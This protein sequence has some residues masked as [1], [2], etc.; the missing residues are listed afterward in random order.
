MLVVVVEGLTDSLLSRV[1]TPALD[2][3]IATGVMF[4]LEPEFPAETLPTI[5]S[6][7]TGKHTEIHGVIDTEVEEGGGTL[8]YRE[9]DFWN[10]NPNIS[11]LWSLNEEKHHK[12]G[13]VWWPGTECH[14]VDNQTH[15]ALLIWKNSDILDNNSS[16]NSNQTKHVEKRSIVMN[17]ELEE[18]STTIDDYELEEEI[19]IQDNDGDRKD[20]MT[21]VGDDM[22]LNTLDFNQS[23]DQEW[24]TW[25]A[26]ISSTVDWLMDGNTNLV[27]LFVKEPGTAIRSFGPGS[28]EAEDALVKVDMMVG[29][30]MQE[31]G[32]HKLYEKVDIIVTGVHGFTEVSTENVIEISSLISDSSSFAVFGHSPVLNIHPTPG[33]DLDVYAGLSQ[34]QGDKYNVYTKNLIPDNFFYKNNDRVGP[35]VMVAREGNVFSSSFWGDIKVLNEKQGRTQNLDNKY[36]FSGYDNRLESMQSVVI[37]RGPGIQNKPTKLDQRQTLK[38]VDIFPL[39]CH[40]LDITPPE[41]NGSLAIIQHYLHNAPP[42]P[43]IHQ[44]KKLVKYYTNKEQLP[45]TVSLLAA[46]IMIMLCLI[47]V[48]CCTVKRKRKLRENSQYKYSQ[49]NYTKLEDIPDTIIQ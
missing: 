43:T 12:T 36:G 47:C 2:S 17:T 8:T 20:N 28:K 4:N 14:P 48:S 10:Y 22:A 9:A 13:S 18:D 3:L 31:L 27:L 35:I 30:L 6:I 49:I 5:Q 1:A 44:I 19:K 39:V 16:N 23:T 26:Q 11:T 32:K 38:A 29:N 25:N 33:K 42:N 40:L 45:L 21:V 7:V 46:T 34:S 24:K 15:N 37:L 41:N